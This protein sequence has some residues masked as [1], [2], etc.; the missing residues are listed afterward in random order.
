MNKNKK[1]ID[2]SVAMFIGARLFAP[3]NETIEETCEKF[4]A[5]KSIEILKRKNIK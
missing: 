2:Y 1:A 5:I 3:E 4:K